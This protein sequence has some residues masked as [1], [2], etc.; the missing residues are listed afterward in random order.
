M[1]S[2]SAINRSSGLLT[3]V[4]YVVKSHLNKSCG[5]PDRSFARLSITTLSSKTL[6]LGSRHALIRIILLLSLT[7]L[8]LR[9]RV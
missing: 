7:R 6:G 1:L 8:D 2:G 5:S 9:R 3:R 4:S